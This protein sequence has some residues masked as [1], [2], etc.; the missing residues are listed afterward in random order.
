MPPVCRVAEM[1]SPL[2]ACWA[3]ALRVSGHT[4]K[5]NEA[6]G[7]E[8]S[9]GPALGVA[10]GPTDGPACGVALAEGVVLALAEG[11]VLALAE[12]VALALAVKVG[13]GAA[14][15]RAGAEPPSP[16]TFGATRP[17]SR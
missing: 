11:V 9:S 10:L 8:L 2:I 3:A 6:Y 5:A 4:R 17:V 14:A 16:P 15:V 13:R 12:G 1:V 7:S